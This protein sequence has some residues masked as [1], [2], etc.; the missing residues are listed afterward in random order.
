MRKILF[1]TALALTA[2]ALVPVAALADDPVATVQADIAKLQSDVQTK[3]DTVVA[4]A[5]ALEAD[6]NGFVGTTD[7]KAARLKIRLDALKL[8]GDWKS[9][10][11]VC[12]GDRAKLRADIKAAHLQGV[13]EQRLRPLV[14]Q[15]NV[16]IRLTNLEMRAAVLK[17]RLAVLKMRAS[18]NA[19]NQAA[20]A[21]PTPPS[22]P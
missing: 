8:T 19:A 22:N 15:A 4:D 14:H 7:K 6:A 21:V 20:P 12:L 18:F 17:A 5:A 16:Q 2:A 3:H 13:T 11:A 1:L 10:R 9:L